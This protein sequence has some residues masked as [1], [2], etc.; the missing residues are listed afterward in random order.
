MQVPVRWLVFLAP[1]KAMSTLIPPI[2]CI[3]SVYVLIVRQ[4]TTD[5]HTMLHFEASCTSNVCSSS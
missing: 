5:E 1:R 3:M 4:I 2:S